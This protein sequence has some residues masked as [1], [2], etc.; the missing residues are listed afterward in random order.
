LALVRVLRISFAKE[1]S[2]ERPIKQYEKITDIVYSWGIES[3]NQVLL[4]QYPDKRHLNAVKTT[5]EFPR[6]SG[7][8]H[9]ETGPGKWLKRYFELK[10]SGIYHYKDTKVGHP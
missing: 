4:R 9:L 5:S 2:V 6:M 8:I 1:N 7:V 3:T 10:F